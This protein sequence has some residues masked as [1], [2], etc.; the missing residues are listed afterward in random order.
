VCRGCQKDLEIKIGSVVVDWINFDEMLA[1]WQ[2]ALHY[3]PGR[4]AQGGWA[5]LQDPDGKNTSVSLNQVLP[6]E[7]LS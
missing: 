7:K 5:I 1:F 2:D 6:S 3:V 4:P